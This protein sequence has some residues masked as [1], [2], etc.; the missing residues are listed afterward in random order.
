MIKDPL[1]AYL[2]GEISKSQMASQ[3]ESL[4]Q[5]ICQ[6]NFDDIIKQAQIVSEKTCL[7]FEEALEQ[8]IEKIIK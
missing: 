6:E 8:E 2:S 1:C 7:T 5:Q 4:I 3:Y